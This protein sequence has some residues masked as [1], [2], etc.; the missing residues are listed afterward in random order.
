MY[1]C[2]LNKSN[3]HSASANHLSFSILNY[4]VFLSYFCFCIAGYGHAFARDAQQS[5]CIRLAYV[6]CDWTQHWIS[7]F[8]ILRSVVF[9]QCGSCPQSCEYDYLS[10]RLVQPQQPLR[11]ALPVQLSYPAKKKYAHAVAYIIK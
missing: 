7:I 6:L 11:D 5:N 3:N 9:T 8:H 2:M 10:N 4:S 1:M